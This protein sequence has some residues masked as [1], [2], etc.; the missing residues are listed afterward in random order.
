MASLLL[1]KELSS[2]QNEGTFNMLSFTN[3]LMQSKQKFGV[4]GNLVAGMLQGI[5]DQRIMLHEINA[6][7]M[8]YAECLSS[9]EGFRLDRNLCK[10]SMLDIFIGCK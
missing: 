10:Q 1:M 8:P 3:D 2:Y 4:L 7:L 5:P 9:L 6:L